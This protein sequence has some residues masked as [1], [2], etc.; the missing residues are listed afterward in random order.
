[1]FLQLFPMLPKQI[2]R[3]VKASIRQAFEVVPKQFTQR[4]SLL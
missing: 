4:T 1:M 2:R 3:L